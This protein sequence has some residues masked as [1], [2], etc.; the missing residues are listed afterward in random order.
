VVKIPDTEAEMPTAIDYDPQTETLQVGAGRIERVSPQVWAYEV[1]GWRVVTNE[2]AEC[3]T[4]W[5]TFAQVRRS[6]NIQLLPYSLVSLLRAIFVSGRCCGVSR[7]GPPCPPCGLALNLGPHP[8]QAHPAGTATRQCHG[9][10]SSAPHVDCLCL[11]ARDRTCPPD[12]ARGWH[13]GGWQGYKRPG[14]SCVPSALS[15][16]GRCW[17]RSA[18]WIGRV[19]GKGD[20]P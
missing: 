4:R 16:N 12:V 10:C 19:T 13:D 3:W 20:G 14:W 6:S 11:T 2:K 17:P 15:P 8:D 1:S 18:C 5:K 7:A 9:P